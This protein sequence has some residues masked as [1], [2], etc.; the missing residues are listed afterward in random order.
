MEVTKGHTIDI[1]ISGIELLKALGY[2]E[3]DFQF[4]DIDRA[5]ESITIIGRKEA[6][7]VEKEV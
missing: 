1:K 6:K 2:D 5:N 7:T 3:Y 4:L